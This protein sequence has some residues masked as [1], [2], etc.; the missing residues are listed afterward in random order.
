MFRLSPR[1]KALLLSVLAA[2]ALAVFNRSHAGTA[3]PDP[4]LDSP[5]VAGKS[6][7]T[8]VFAGGCFW[9][10]EAVFEHVRG[11]SDVVSGYAAGNVE[12]EN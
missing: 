9:G 12:T 1:K 3:L 4:K 2:S 10:V 8:A 7:Q 11:V 5:K 6:V